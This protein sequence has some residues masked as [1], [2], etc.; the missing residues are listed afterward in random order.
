ME[1]LHPSVCICVKDRYK[2][3]PIDRQTS[4][5]SKTKASIRIYFIIHLT[6]HIRIFTIHTLHRHQIK[7][8]HITTHKLTDTQI[9]RATHIPLSAPSAPWSVKS[10]ILKHRHGFAVRR[11]RKGRMGRAVIISASMRRMLSYWM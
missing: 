1:W 3:L 7:T 11:F 5:H 10:P 2:C 6:C 8:K 9:S 4:T